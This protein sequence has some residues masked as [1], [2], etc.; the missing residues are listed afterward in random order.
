MC[1]IEYSKLHYAKPE[2]NIIDVQNPNVDY[3][4]WCIYEHFSEHV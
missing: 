3:T 1:I 4:V 2:T